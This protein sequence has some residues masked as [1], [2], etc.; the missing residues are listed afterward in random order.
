M[1]SSKKAPASA[2]ADRE[3]VIV[4]LVD[5][6]LARVWRAWSDPIEI[7]KWWGPHGFSD[8]TVERDFRPGG[9]WKHTMIGP[10]G[11]R[12]PNFVRYEEIV[13]GKHLVYTNGNGLENSK[14]DIH[15]RS[16]VTFKA[17][18]PK[19]E[20]TL[21]TVLPTAE[22]RDRVVKHHNAIEGGNQTLA[23]LEAHV[24]GHFVLSRLVDAPRARV[25]KAWTDPAELAAWFGPKGFVTT[26]AD[27]DLRPGGTYHYALRGPGIELWALWTFSAVEVPSRL[28]FVSQFSDPQRRLTVHPMAPTWPKRTLS[29]VHFQDFGPKTLVTLYCAPIDATDTELAT[30]RD[31]MSSMNAG[32]GGTFDRLDAHLAE[33]MP[34]G[35]RPSG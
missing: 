13:E 15:F 9:S 19:T 31:G 21:R 2:T 34:S 8:E 23:R 1:D 20:I 35:A 11:A 14:A 18:G 7:V 33:G 27:L 17:V 10:D 3:L 16:H 22:M 6:P 25:W 4:R 28:E 29:T 24:R 12:Y 32:W 26:H 30:F 5:A